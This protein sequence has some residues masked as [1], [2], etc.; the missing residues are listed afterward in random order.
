MY[1]VLKEDVVTYSLN[2]NN[3]LMLLN[4]EH[5]NLYTVKI[6]FIS[7]IVCCKKHDYKWNFSCCRTQMP[8]L[9]AKV[10]RGITPEHKQ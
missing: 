3:I 9:P 6:S 10:N 5:K 1:F 7:D 4:L 2:C 8:P